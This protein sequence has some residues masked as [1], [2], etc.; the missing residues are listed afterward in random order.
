MAGLKGVA[1]DR[2]GDETPCSKSQW[3]EGRAK[4]VLSTK[5]GDTIVRERSVFEPTR[6]ELPR[7]AALTW[8]NR[9]KGKNAGVRHQGDGAR[10]TRLLYLE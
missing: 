3:V 5:R 7:M 6:G 10:M 8:G 9:G 4:G 2:I 1:R